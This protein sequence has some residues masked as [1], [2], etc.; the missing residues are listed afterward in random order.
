MVVRRIIACLLIPFLA[1][2]VGSVTGNEAGLGLGRLDT[3]SKEEIEN[4]A[5]FDEFYGRR[6]AQ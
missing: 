6:K 3:I 4:E 2:C 5:W 1:G